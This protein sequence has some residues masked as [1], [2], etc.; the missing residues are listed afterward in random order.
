[1][2]ETDRVR[3]LGIKVNMEGGVSLTI[4]F[5]L[6]VN[7]DCHNLLEDSDVVFN[8]LGSIDFTV[9]NTNFSQI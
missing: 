5:T 2:S 8:N 9:G 6:I 7:L 1:M 4:P 3:T